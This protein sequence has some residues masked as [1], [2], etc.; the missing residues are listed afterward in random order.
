LQ[1]DGSSAGV[2]TLLPFLSSVSF[3]LVL[4]RDTLLTTERRWRFVA[5]LGRR[6]CLMLVWCGV[7][8]PQRSTT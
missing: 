7:F 8:G 5:R 1:K 4:D 6:F 2:E 3:R